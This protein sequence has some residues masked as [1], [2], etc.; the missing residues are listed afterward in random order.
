MKTKIYI[1][2]AYGYERCNNCWILNGKWGEAAILSFI[3]KHYPAGLA[4]MLA[5]TSTYLDDGRE[6][7][8]FEPLAN[9]TR[10]YARAKNAAAILWLL[11]HSDFL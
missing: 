11:R 3:Q 5:V 2:N 1:T 4:G 6:I 9:E 7:E 10:E 8:S